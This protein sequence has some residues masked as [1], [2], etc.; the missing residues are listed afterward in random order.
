M[1]PPVFLFEPAFIPPRSETSVDV[2]DVT[3]AAATPLY[4]A[5]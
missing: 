2:Q 4:A 3:C 1:L 5:D